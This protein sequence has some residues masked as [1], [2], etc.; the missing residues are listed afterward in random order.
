M[1]LPSGQRQYVTNPPLIVLCLTHQSAGQFPKDKF[2]P[3]KHCDEEDLRRIVGDNDTDLK[4]SA[5]ADAVAAATRPAP[6]MA[7][8]YWICLRSE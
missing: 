8:P 5:M 2:G 6:M 1:L 7:Q 3:W 4:L